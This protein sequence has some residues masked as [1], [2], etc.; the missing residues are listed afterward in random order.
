[1]P[2]LS[3]GASSPGSYFNVNGIDYP[4][5]NYEVQYRNVQTTVLGSVL[6]IGLKNKYNGVNLIS[7]EIFS[8]WTDSSDTPYGSIDELLTAF[9]ELGV[10]ENALE[11]QYVFDYFLVDSPDILMWI[12]SSGL[13]NTTEMNTSLAVVADAT[14][15]G[16]EAIADNALRHIRPIGYA[17][18]DQKIKSLF[19]NA[20]IGGEDI[21]RICIFKATYPDGDYH[22]VNGTVTVLLNE[23]LSV[24]K[25]TFNAEDFISTSIAATEVIYAV[26]LSVVLT[27]IDNNLLILTTTPD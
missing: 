9:T 7:P 2:K 5:G 27:N 19:F 14:N 11:I 6:Q 4:R 15:T 8:N 17:Q 3:A 18:V 13:N 10:V 1:M 24:E 26:L 21:T 20:G 23:A 12:G 25:T 22:Q 16:I